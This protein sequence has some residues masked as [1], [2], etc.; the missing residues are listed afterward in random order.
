MR[1][2]MTFV[3]EDGDE[4]IHFLATALLNANA[5]I[6]DNFELT[7]LVSIVLAVLLLKIFSWHNTLQLQ[8]A[9][10]FCYVDQIN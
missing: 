5:L 6:M 1:F 10:V 2:E 7:Q 3:C 8:I 9:L 4:D